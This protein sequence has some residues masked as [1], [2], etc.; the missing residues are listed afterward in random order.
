M[1]HIFIVIH[2]IIILIYDIQSNTFISD[3]IQFI[4]TMNL[5]LYSSNSN[6]WIQTLITISNN[7]IH[8]DISINQLLFDYDHWTSNEIIT[9][10]V[11]ITNV[12]FGIERNIICLVHPSATYITHIINTID[13]TIMNSHVIILLQNEVMDILNTISTFYIVQDIDKDIRPYTRI[14]IHSITFNPESDGYI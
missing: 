3:K 11:N 13:S 8:T 6:T 4:Q 5:S 2:G 7:E 12:L 10:K 9:Y 14:S 1:Y